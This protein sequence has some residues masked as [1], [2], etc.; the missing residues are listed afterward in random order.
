LQSIFERKIQAIW[1]TEPIAILEKPSYP[2][3]LKALI[4]VIESK[5]WRWTAPAR[6]VVSAIKMRKRLTLK[7]INIDD[8]EQVRRLLSLI[9]GSIWWRITRPFRKSI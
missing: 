9:Q 3:T 1:P 6:A 4:S 2:Q 7:Q 8:E 5:S